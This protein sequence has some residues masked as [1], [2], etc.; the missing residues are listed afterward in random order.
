MTT[1][2]ILTA[3]RQ[4]PL[5]RPFSEFSDDEIWQAIEIKR[6]TDK[7]GSSEGGADLKTPEWEAFTNP[8]SL[9]DSDDFELREIDPPEPFRD[10]FERVIKVERIREVRALTGFTRIESP[11][12]YDD[13]GTIPEKQR[14]PLSRK[15]PLWVPAAEIRGE[16]IFIQ[17]R[18]ELILDWAKKNA[19]RES[20]FRQAHINWRRVRDIEPAEAGF[21]GIRYV[22]L[23]S[24]AHA[25]MRQITLECG[26]TAASIRERIYSR[27]AGTDS[28]PMSGVLIF[29]G[30]NDSE[31][32]LGGLASLAQPQSLLRHIDQALE[33]MRLCASDPLCGEHHPF[34]EG[35]TLHGAACHACLF[36]PETSCERGNK[37]LDRTVLVRTFDSDV[38][39][40]FERSV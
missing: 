9:G 35:I 26:Y 27:N 23:H 31:G 19:E 11:G 22:L 4:T 2:D 29:T 1:K 6:S 40:F 36:A 7:N 32:T 37:Y 25:L 8:G 12:D 34:K 5:L 24:F 20:E 14:A 3:F 16:G 15:P 38:V 33:A 39:A 10:V 13:I 28:P 30:A 18:E 17:F 21:P